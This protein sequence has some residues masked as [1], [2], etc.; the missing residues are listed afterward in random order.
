MLLEP[1]ISGGVKQATKTP[2]TERAAAATAL[3]LPVEDAS[4]YVEL[5]DSEIRLGVLREWELGFRRP[6]DDR[7]GLVILEREREKWRVVVD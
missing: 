4:E 3:R 1:L 7:G 6:Y 5:G 2:A